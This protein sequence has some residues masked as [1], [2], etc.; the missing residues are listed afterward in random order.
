[1]SKSIKSGHSPAS[2]EEPRRRRTFARVVPKLRGEFETFLTYR[3]GIGCEPGKLPDELVF[4]PLKKIN[5]ADRVAYAVLSDIGKFMMRFRPDE[6]PIRPWIDVGAGPGVR[7]LQL[8]VCA[9]RDYGIDFARLRAECVT[10]L[11]NLIWTRENFNSEVLKGDDIRLRV[12]MVNT[13][14]KG[15]IQVECHYVVEHLKV[16]FEVEAQRRGNRVRP[17]TTIFDHRGEPFTYPASADTRG[18]D[19]PAKDCTLVGRIRKVSDSGGWHA[20][21]HVSKQGTKTLRLLGH[22]VEV[23]QRL[24]RS[25][26]KHSFTVTPH[27][28][29]LGGFEY[30]SVYDLVNPIGP[31]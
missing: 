25:Q 2:S 16:R 31:A 14:G 19:L 27:P 6:W 15:W 23:I 5:A 22:Q 24:H 1:M 20:E 26:S 10:G 3:I 13:V 30:C 12:G 9:P 29:T 18:F 11:G 4:H 21:I 7:V 28:W 8:S 17:A